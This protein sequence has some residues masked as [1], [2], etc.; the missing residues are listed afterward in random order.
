MFHQKVI[1][2]AA[3]RRNNR[4]ALQDIGNLVAKQA[5]QNVTKRNTR[6]FYANNQ[7]A[8]EK[9]KKSST[10][11]ANGA[12]VV[13]ANGGWREELHCYNKVRSS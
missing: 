8:V 4:R 1:V 12:G 7:A 13:P 9:N 2:A 3:E 5:E 6:K 11:L 10:E